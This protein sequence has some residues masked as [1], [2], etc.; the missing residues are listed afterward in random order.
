M[1]SASVTNLWLN[2]KAGER[3]NE[4]AKAI[5]T[6]QQSFLAISE[7]QLNHCFV[8]IT[9]FIKLFYKLMWRVWMSGIIIEL[10][11]TWGNSAPSLL[12]FSFSL[13]PFIK[14]NNF[15]YEFYS[16]TCFLIRFTVLPIKNTK[17]NH[18][19]KQVKRKRRKNILY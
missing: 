13:L 14:L 10:V 16:S 4:T 9:N 5:K 6:K 7:L 18:F 11:Y 2:V 8:E 15:L 19:S 17:L 12:F 1:R 3:H